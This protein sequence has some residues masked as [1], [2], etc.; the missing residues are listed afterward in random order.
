M[1]RSGQE[2]WI[3]LTGLP[4]EASAQALARVLIERRLA[5]CVQIGAPVRAF[6]R[7]AGAL[8]SALEVPLSAKT[9]A[10]GYP[11]LEAAVRAHHPYELPEILAVPART[12]ALD[13]LAWVAAEVEGTAAPADGTGGNKTGCDA[14]D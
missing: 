4:D 8:Q 1:Q 12:G 11:A 6:Y 10:A 2:V 13:Y 14:N 7:W 5:A 9:T 3:V